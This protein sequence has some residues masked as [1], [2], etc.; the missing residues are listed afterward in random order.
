MTTANNPGYAKL[1]QALEQSDAR[2]REGRA[3]RILWL[4]QHQ[5]SY[6]MIS[7]PMDTMRLL[8]EA[9]ECFID[10]HY[11]AVILLAVAFIEH[12]LIDELTEHN[13]LG[14]VSTLDSAI[15]AAR[16]ADL[17]SEK[18]LDRADALRKIRNPFS[19]RKAGHID[20]FGAR[21]LAQQQHPDLILEADAKESLQV[22]YDFL[23]LTLKAA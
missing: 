12:S 2:R 11:V 3:E 20:S 10:A 7:G 15:R 22:M 1:L 18:L 21:F 17:F 13:L 4:S 16:K 23:R 14:Q 19:H 6:E 9:R 5:V 8:S